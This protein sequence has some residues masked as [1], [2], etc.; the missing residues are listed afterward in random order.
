MNSVDRTID[1]ENSLSVYIETFKDNGNKKTPEFDENITKKLEKQH[2]QINETLQEIK[3]L[4]YYKKYKEIENRMI[5]N[6]IPLLVNH[7]LDEATVLYSYIFSKVKKGSGHY[8]KFIACSDRMKEVGVQGFRFLIKY[9]APNSIEQDPDT[10][11]SD[12]D[13]VRSLFA[14]AMDTEESFLFF[15][16][17]QL[18]HQN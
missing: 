8:K 7:L 13:T 18:Q 1:L 17:Q 12:F 4:I 11:I 5:S 14:S 10:F 16:H 9:Q 2:V 6:F 15:L 3:I